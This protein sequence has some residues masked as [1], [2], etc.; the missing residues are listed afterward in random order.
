M[1][2]AVSGT[3]ATGK[4]T[5]VAALAPLLPHYQLVEEPYYALLDE[6]HAFAAEPS[7]EDFEL[8]LERSLRMLAG[9][10]APD[11]LF[12]RCP[13]DY[14]GYLAALPGAGAETLA[15]WL[16][17]AAEALAS[18]GLIVFVPIER[19]DRA[20]AAVTEGRRL[21]ARVDAVLREMLVDDAWGLDA[22]VLEVRGTPEDRAR[23]VVAHLAGRP[24]A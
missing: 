5:L 10:A 11:V 13:A 2:I 8:Q 17:P 19:P 23:Q 16:P 20:G 7:R 6:G 1:R 12:D 22:R 15:A 21:R 4:S 3:H 14:L 18:L 9:T 24:G